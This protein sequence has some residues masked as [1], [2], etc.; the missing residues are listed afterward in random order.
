MRLRR[1]AFRTPGLRRSFGV[2]ERMMASG[3]FIA[4]SSTS[5]SLPDMPGSISSIDLMPP[6]FFMDCIWSRKSSSVK[7]AVRAFLASFSASS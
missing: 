6:I 2:M 1:L 5:M 7:S 4:F 3:F